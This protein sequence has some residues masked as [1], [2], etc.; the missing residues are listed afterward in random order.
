M[1]RSVGAFRFITVTDSANERHF[2]TVWQSFSLLIL[3]TASLLVTTTGFI[4]VLSQ[5]ISGA[6]AGFVLSFALASSTGLL[7]LLERLTYLDQSMVAVER[8]NEGK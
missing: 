8:L 7:G 1:D 6:S 2:C 3:T 5:D 4:L